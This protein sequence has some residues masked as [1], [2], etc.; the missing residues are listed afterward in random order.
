MAEQTDDW[1]S[2][3]QFRYPDRPYGGGERGLI[4]DSAQLTLISGHIV[5]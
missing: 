5:I 3:R 2:V 1:L 4:A